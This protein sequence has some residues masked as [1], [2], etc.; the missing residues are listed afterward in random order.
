ML[1]DDNITN[2]TVGNNILKQ[3][4]N[5]MTLNSAERLFQVLAK[6]T[7][8]LILLDIEMP[9]MNGYEAI[10]ILKEKDEFKEI[11]VIFLTAKTDV[12]SE[13]EGLTLGAIDYI[14]KPFSPP[15]LLKRLELHLLLLSQ[16]KE[17]DRQHQE[18]MA[19]NKNLQQMVDEK[20]KT[21]VELKNAILST[22]SDLVD[23]RDSN[24]GGHIERTQKYLSMLIDSLWKNPEYAKEAS[25]WDK[26][27]LLQSAQ[28]HD[29]GKISID[30]SILR[31][32]DKLTYDEYT[33]IQMHTEI[34]SMIIEGIEKKS[35]HQ[36]FLAQA[37][38][39]AATHHEKWD[40]SGY[41]KGLSGSDI[42]LQ[43]RLMALADV[44]DA[45]V[46]D[47]PYR[48][49][50]SHEEAVEIILKD[51]G[52]HFDPE[53]VEIFISVSGEFKEAAAQFKAQYE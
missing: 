52:V 1:V 36:D 5:I 34:G 37:K 17:L 13:L 47:R 22:M 44:Y 53:L 23:R 8:D 41:P 48:K 19:F 10:K 51:K 39:L 25:D 7:P 12:D 16:K 21:V 38:I 11:P 26:D 32:P 45:L 20:T 43:G 33:K 18:L 6:V 29:I 46:S 4:Y 9:E 3:D 42:P 40:G 50:M 14:G 35:S 30:D 2:L 15:L 28:L 27:L 31:K 49:A 24:T